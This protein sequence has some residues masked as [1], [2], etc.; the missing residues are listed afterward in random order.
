[1]SKYNI[2][3]VLVHVKQNMIDFV[4]QQLACQGGVEVHAKSDDGRLIVTV[5]DETR[6]TVGQRIMGFYEINGVLSASMIYQFSDDEFNENEEI[7]INIEKDSQPAKTTNELNISE[8][9]MSA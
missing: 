3:S 2:C 5:E 1:M 7:E 9:R 4:R 8:E 6:K